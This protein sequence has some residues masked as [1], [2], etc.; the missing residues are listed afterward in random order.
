[1]E[2]GNHANGANE[3]S[4]TQSPI[5][6]LKDGEIH[7]ERANVKTFHFHETKPHKWKEDGLLLIQSIYIQEAH[8]LRQLK[9]LHRSGNSFFLGLSNEPVNHNLIT[10][11]QR[12]IH[13]LKL[14]KE[15]NA[16]CK[17]QVDTAEARQSSENLSAI[18][19][20][21]DDHNTDIV[22]LLQQLYCRL[23]TKGKTCTGS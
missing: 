15:R 18:L 17:M 14:T 8:N 5:L 23:V 21:K 20:N 13:L 7:S 19:G 11:Y 3:T 1:M 4:L 6:F 16:R 12:L 10:S 9:S 22:D 2:N